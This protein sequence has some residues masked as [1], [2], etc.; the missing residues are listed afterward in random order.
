MEPEAKPACDKCGSTN[1][2]EQPGDIWPGLLVCQEPGCDGI[3]L[4]EAGA[5]GLE[6]AMVDLWVKEKMRVTGLN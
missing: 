5:Q 4:T 3:F 6:E 1:M 2:R